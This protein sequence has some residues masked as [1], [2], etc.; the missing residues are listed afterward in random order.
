MA[1]WKK[2]LDFVSAPLSQ[3]K[4]FLT[5]GWT[6]AAKKVGTTRKAIS[7]G[8][9]SGWK[10]I[11]TTVASTAVLAGA[12]LAIAGG[13]GG[14]AGIAARRT[15][16][17]APSIAKKFIPKSFVG[18]TVAV[19]AAPAVIGAVVR[20]PGKAVGFVLEA[21]GEIAELGGDLAA[22]GYDPSLESAKD[23]ITGSPLIAA[24]LAVA[25][26]VVAAPAV[27]GV[28]G[29]VLAQKERK[30]QTELLEDISKEKVLDTAVVAPVAVAPENQIIK[31]K[32]LGV[33]GAPEQPKTTSIKSAPRKRYKR[34]VA[35]KAPQV[36]NNVR[37]NIVNA[38]KVT[39]LSMKRY[40]KQ[41]LLA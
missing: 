21:P 6:A 11:G 26:V 14:A 3:P 4:T 20:S 41:E 25:G 36:R 39:G 34:R 24:G 33:A 22:F 8:K 16:F 10:V 31:E 1:W 32:P 30:A 29:N 15:V 7:T 17:R 37:V 38:P 27:A 35:K 28:V 23:V 18:R 12:T 19:L 9:A 5:K 2:A 13:A 40:I